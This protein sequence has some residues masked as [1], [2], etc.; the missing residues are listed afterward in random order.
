M[1]YFCIIYIEIKQYLGR[2]NK[3]KNFEKLDSRSFQVKNERYNKFRWVTLILF[4]LSSIYLATLYLP[5][6]IEFELLYYF[7]IPLHHMSLY[8]INICFF[9]VRIK[10]GK[11]NKIEIL[12]LIGMG[13]SVAAF[14]LVALYH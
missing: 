8:F 4:V 7:F 13:S 9:A 3:S 2:L 1:F 11:N 6:Y 14:G 5:Q 12:I 10:K